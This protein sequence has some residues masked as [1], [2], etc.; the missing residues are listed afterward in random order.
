MG[1]GRC[2]LAPQALRRALAVA[3]AA[4]VAGVGERPR[5]G[6]RGG[7]VLPLPPR[8]PAQGAHGQALARAATSQCKWGGNVRCRVTAARCARVLLARAAASPR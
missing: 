2:A 4:G 1:A 7:H 3:V 5:R 8:P 6:S